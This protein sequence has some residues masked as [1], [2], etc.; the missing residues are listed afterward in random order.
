MPLSESYEYPRRRSVEIE[1]PLGLKGW[2]IPRGRR[3]RLALWS[4]ALLCL[5]FV[6]ARYSETGTFWMV[7]LLVAGFELMLLLF[8][9]MPGQSQVLKDTAVTNVYSRGYL[10]FCANFFSLLIGTVIFLLWRRFPG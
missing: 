9:S 3:L 8:S 5:P 2:G 6:A 7:T 10:W 1:V 4:V